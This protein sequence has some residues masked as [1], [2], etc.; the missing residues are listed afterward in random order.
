MA[1]CLP[2][3]LLGSSIPLTLQSEVSDP[4]F[5]DLAAN[6]RSSSR[7]SKRASVESQPGLSENP[8]LNYQRFSG[9]E[10]R[11]ANLSLDGV[12]NLGTPALPGREQS[13]R[14]RRTKSAPPNSFTHPVVHEN[15]VGAGMRQLEGGRGKRSGS[16]PIRPSFPM[17]DL[18]E[19]D[20]D[21]DKRSLASSY[22]RNS[23]SLFPSPR[24]SVNSIGSSRLSTSSTLTPSLPSP[25]LRTESRASLANSTTPLHTLAEDEELTT[26]QSIDSR[27]SSRSPLRS[28][29]RTPSISHTR[30]RSSSLQSLADTSSISDPHSLDASTPSPYQSSLS[31]RVSFSPN[32]DE[33]ITIN[34]ELEENI[35]TSEPGI[36]RRQSSWS[37]FLLI[38]APPIA[39]LPEL[40]QRTS[41]S[42]IRGQAAGRSIL[43][44]TS[45][46]QIGETAEQNM[47]KIKRKPVPTPGVWVTGR[48]S[49][50]ERNK[51][52]PQPMSLPSLPEDEDDIDDYYTNMDLTPVADQDSFPC[53]SSLPLSPYS[54][55]N[56]H[57]SS[58]S[59]EYEDDVPP[60]PFITP[61]TPKAI[62]FSKH[63]RHSVHTITVPSSSSSPSG[64]PARMFGSE[65]EQLSG[66]HWSME[67]VGSWVRQ[68]GMRVWRVEGNVPVVPRLVT[69]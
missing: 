17:I 18:D 45:S 39:A 40:T 51:S 29:S 50:S 4:G 14:F 31:K 68:S 48:E 23:Y 2:F 46:F 54:S 65:D 24:D 66:R 16:E 33:V 25:A 55:S 60:T 9:Y 19:I 22:K 41:M 30:S 63:T 64:K 27:S 61:A 6:Q 11:R 47:D 49:R 56:S 28:H 57:A 43:R 5:S 3:M 69:A 58:S 13:G 21:S 59:D 7:L 36:L 1:S 42:S 62:T 38:S 53:S 52:P 44:R 34:D 12:P 15:W 20:D 26:P 32:A 67:G 8:T 10:R 35:N 37:G